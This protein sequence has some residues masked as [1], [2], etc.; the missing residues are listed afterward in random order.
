MYLFMEIIGYK[1]QQLKNLIAVS[2]QTRMVQLENKTKLGP[3]N[4]RQ[5]AAV[6]TCVSTVRCW[7]T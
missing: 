7:S 6:D 1:H 5:I 4:R 2:C 3:N